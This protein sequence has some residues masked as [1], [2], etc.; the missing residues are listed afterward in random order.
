MTASQKRRFL[1]KTDLKNR[2]YFPK[3]KYILEDRVKFLSRSVKPLRRIFPHHLRKFCFETLYN[4]AQ[5]YVQ[6]HVYNKKVNYIFFWK[7]QVDITRKSNLISHNMPCLLL[8]FTPTKKLL[9]KINYLLFERCFNFVS[10]TETANLSLLRK[11]LSII[12]EKLYL[13]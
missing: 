8:Y 7:S 10:H 6:I 13:K 5:I 3:Y 1:S 9:I 11:I 12:R 4:C 2:N